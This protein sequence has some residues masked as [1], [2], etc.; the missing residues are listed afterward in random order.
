M[1][2]IN[3]HRYVYLEQRYRK[4]FDEKILDELRKKDFT[5]IIMN[6]IDNLKS[7]T[8]KK[9]F[10][11]GGEIFRFFY[12]TI[13]TIPQNNVCLVWKTTNM[14]FKVIFNPMNC[15][16]NVQYKLG[17]SV[18]YEYT[19]KRIWF[20]YEHF[21][22]SLITDFIEIC[23]TKMK[24]DKQKELSKNFDDVYKMF[25]VYFKKQITDAYSEKIYNNV[26]NK[27]QQNDGN[28]VILIYF[29]TNLFQKTAN[30]GQIFEFPTLSSDYII[31]GTVTYLNWDNEPHY[32]LTIHTVADQ[33]VFSLTVKDSFIKFV[34]DIERNEHEI[35]HASSDDVLDGFYKTMYLEQIANLKGNT[36]SCLSEAVDKYH[37][38]ISS[39]N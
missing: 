17:E 12:P 13:E 39:N 35:L 38:S 21:P 8:E 10:A 31:G 32:N 24:E 36:S 3:G 4:D 37:A 16:I 26:L 34:M 7:A 33:I 23:K 1:S 28:L 25:C 27:I 29:L 22:R 30:A 15:W 5:M 2:K 18:Y 19:V 9:S 20:D 6:F 11:E 14:E